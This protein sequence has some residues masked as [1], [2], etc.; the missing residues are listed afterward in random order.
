MRRVFELIKRLRTIQFKPTTTYLPP[1]A[2]KA[3][4]RT[5]SSGDFNVKRQAIWGMS[6]ATLNKSWK[7]QC[8][9]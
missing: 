4:D 1:L 2:Q 8:V 7:A 5:V 9:S 6:A 3:L